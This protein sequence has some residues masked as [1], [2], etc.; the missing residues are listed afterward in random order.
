MSSVNSSINN[1]IGTFASVDVGTYENPNNFVCIDTSN[2]RIG[3]NN[4]YP[5]YSIDISGSS[6]T[7]GIITNELVVTG[8]ISCNKFLKIKSTDL[9]FIDIS[10]TNHSGDG[11]P[12][13]INPGQIYVDISG[14]LKMRRSS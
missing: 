12:T 1:L 10:F 4:L 2:N 11:I 14:F 7:D 9:S 5:Q 6:Q 3:I 13:G 8:D